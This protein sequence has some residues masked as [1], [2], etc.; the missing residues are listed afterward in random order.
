MTSITTYENLIK[1]IPVLKQSTKIKRKVW[2]R[3]S[4]NNKSEIENDI[5]GAEAEVEISREDI[6]NE[7][8]TKK[9]IVMTLMWGYPTGGRGS[10]IA[11]LL[12]NLS[13][14]NTTLGN[15]KNK[16]LSYADF[17]DLVQSFNEILGL[18]MSTWSK[19]LYVFNVKID[20][21]RCQIYDL[22]I[23]ESLNKKQFVE[24]GSNTWEQNTKNY[25]SYIQLTKNLANTMSSSPD[26]VELFLFYYNYYYKF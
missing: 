3:I 2:E 21:T 16:N 5:F 17:N 19:F 13:K 4:Y 8:D 25:C 23:V 18:G 11:N 10:N 24:L 14:L 9:K 20:S 26:Q 22:K 1:N 12:K 15:I 6:F 7:S